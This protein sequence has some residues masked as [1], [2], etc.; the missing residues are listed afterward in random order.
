METRRCKVRIEV[1]K[2]AGRSVALRRLK[3]I[4]A[5]QRTLPSSRSSDNQ[6]IEIVG[7]KW[8]AP[9]SEDDVT[10]EQEMVRVMI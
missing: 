4:A 5:E 10:F 8:P 9:L 6:I 2:R 1:D 7:K 3:P